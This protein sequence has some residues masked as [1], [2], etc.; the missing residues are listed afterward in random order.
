MAKK[1]F[2]LSSEVEPFSQVYSLSTFSQK[3][4]SRLHNIQD[5]DIRLNQPKYGYISER[6]YILREV[7]RLKEMVIDFSN[8]QEIVNLKSAFIPNSR[9][10]IYFTESDKFFAPISELL[11][12]SKNGRDYR[13]NDFK[14]AF[15]SKV[16]LETIKRLFWYPDII[17][18]ND[19]QMS[20]L[21]ILLNQNYKNDEFYKN[22]K[23]V[24]ILHSINNYR[25]VS[26]ESYEYINLNPPANRIDN[27]EQAIKFSDFL[28]IVDDEKKINQKKFKKSKRLVSASKKTKTM[29]LE[30]SSSAKWSEIS[31]K[32]EMLL[33]KI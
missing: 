7:I 2:Y 23:T 4:C 18:C 25:Y 20:F 13:D 12:K 5:F 24:F 32:V 8:S 3:I 9:V 21:P 14:Y 17:V 33:R 1:I 27:L 10:Q 31:K 6:K 15:F 16:A 19:W 30:V 28:I 22:T 11:Y 29:F 26:N